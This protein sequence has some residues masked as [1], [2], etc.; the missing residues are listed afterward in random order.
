MNAFGAI[1]GLGLPRLSDDAIHG[2]VIFM[3][4]APNP[5]RMA[6]IWRDLRVAFPGN[7]TAQAEKLE[8]LFKW[9]REGE[10]AGVQL[11]DFLKKGPSTLTKVSTSGAYN[12]LEHL[13]MDLRWKNIERLEAG[14]GLRRFVDIV[15]RVPQANGTEKLVYKELKALAEGSA[16]RFAAQVRKDIDLAIRRVAQSLPPGTGRNTPEFI[17]ALR[18]ELKRLHYVFRGSPQG[19]TEVVTLMRKEIAKALTGAKTGSDLASFVSMDFLFRS[20]PY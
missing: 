2:I 12:V 5:R 9:I 11:G 18:E 16:F 4:V 10:A 19:M 1:V 17:A 6:N 15:V 8:N 20:V 3:R 7:P 13:A 14:V